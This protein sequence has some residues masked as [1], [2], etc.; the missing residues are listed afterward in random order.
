M[1]I[2]KQFDRLKLYDDFVFDQKIETVLANLVVLVKERKRFLPNECNSANGKFNCQR[3][4][5]NGFK[6]TGAKLSVNCDGRADHFLRD[7]S[8]P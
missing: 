5:I 2:L 1:N 3:L 4:L 8:I 7:R 6:T